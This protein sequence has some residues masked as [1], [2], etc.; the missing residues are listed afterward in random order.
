MVVSAKT[1]DQCNVSYTRQVL[2]FLVFWILSELFPIYGL[3][4]DRCNA[5]HIWQIWSGPPIIQYIGQWNQSCWPIDEQS[6]RLLMITFATVS[7]CGLIQQGW[8]QCITFAFAWHMAYQT[9]H[10]SPSSC[11]LVV[12]AIQILI[13]QQ[14]N[15]GQQQQPHMRWNHPYSWWI[16]HGEMGHT[17]GQINH[18]MLA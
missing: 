3:F 8:C 14:H 17:Q 11:H 10:Y 16:R 5:S 6:P 1:T 9:Y 15:T 7:I 2:S 13:V 18:F 12:Y 4:G